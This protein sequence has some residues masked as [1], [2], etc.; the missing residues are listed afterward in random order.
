MKNLFFFTG[1]IYLSEDNERPVLISG[2][3]MV[4]AE[5]EYDARI[6]L[7][8]YFAR[9]CKTVITNDLVAIEALNQSLS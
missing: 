5:D 9:Q 8:E 3:F 4:W 7:R 2:P 6:F 1:D